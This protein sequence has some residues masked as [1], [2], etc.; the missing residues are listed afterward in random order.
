MTIA[1]RIKTRRIELGMSQDELAKLIGYSDRAAISRIE[2]EKKDIKHSKL[3]AF[4]KA[5]QMTPAALLGVEEN[6]PMATMLEAMG[7]EKEKLKN[8]IQADYELMLT[9]IKGI[10]DSKKK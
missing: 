8:L 3:L 9:L 5:L 2:A 1:E 10:I 7:F 6:M 4:A